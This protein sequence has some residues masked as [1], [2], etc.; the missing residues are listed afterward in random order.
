MKEVLR[1]RADIETTRRDF[2][3]AVA[4]NEEEIEKERE[5]NGFEHGV[6]TKWDDPLVADVKKMLEEL[7]FANVV[8]A[9]HDAA[10]SRNK[11]EDLR[12]ED[13]S[14]LLLVEVKGILGLLR[15]DDALQVVKYIGR[16]RKRKKELDIRGVCIVNHQRNIPPLT[17]ANQRVF[18][19]AQ[20]GDAENYDFTLV[21]TWDLFR[22][23]HG[24]IEFN[25]P[26]KTIQGLFHVD[27][28]LEPI[29]TH[30]QLIVNGGREVRRC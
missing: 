8:D 20:I 7:G 28:R 15:E 30:Y 29:P 16:W 26:K 23:Y 1:L 14:S 12:I 9:D 2:K 22:L 24:M 5:K 27:G 11:Q 17:R 6:L 3:E 25:W 4:K 10:D 18:T 13:G 19:K 21:T